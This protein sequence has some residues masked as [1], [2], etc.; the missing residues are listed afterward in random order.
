MKT[1]QELYN[2]LLESEELKKA[3]AEV[4]NGDKVEDFLKAHG[5]EAGKEE[6]IAFAKEQQAKLG[7]L[8]DDALDGVAGGANGIEALLS[9][10]TFGVGCAAVAVAS[11]ARDG[12]K[13][14]DGR[15]LCRNVDFDPDGNPSDHSDPKTRGFLR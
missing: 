15:L 3:L 4:I 9:V 14:D 10:L 5:C 12:N 6:L 1:L 2:E 13:S 11:A 7:E 8:S